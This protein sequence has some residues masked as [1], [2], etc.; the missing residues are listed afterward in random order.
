MNKLAILGRFRLAFVKIR[1]SN[2]ISTNIQTPQDVYDHSSFLKNIGFN[3]DRLQNGIFDKNKNITSNSLNTIFK[4]N[5]VS[6]KMIDRYISEKTH[7][8]GYHGYYNRAVTRSVKDIERRMHAYR[9]SEIAKGTDLKTV[10]ELY[11]RKSRREIHALLEDLRT[12]NRDGIDLYKNHEKNQKKFKNQ[13]EMIR[14]LINKKRK[15]NKKEIGITN[16]ED[17]KKYC[18]LMLKIVQ[19]D[20]LPTLSQIFMPMTLIFLECA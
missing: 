20:F 11:I 3:V 4:D 13:K 6:K 8:A 14:S 17:N 7:H 1:K 5:N 2:I 12:M 16:M 19:N 9:Q 10:N 18:L 15:R